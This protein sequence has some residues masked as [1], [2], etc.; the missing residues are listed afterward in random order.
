[1]DGSCRCRSRAT[2][3]IL[4]PAKLRADI[5]VARARSDRLDASKNGSRLAGPCPHQVRAPRTSLGCTLLDPWQFRRKVNHLQGRGG[6]L[7]NH[8]VDLYPP[9]MWFDGRRRWKISSLSP[10]TPTQSWRSMLEVCSFTFR[11]SDRVA[12][13]IISKGSE[14]TQIVCERPLAVA[15]RRWM[16]WTPIS[17]ECGRRSVSSRDRT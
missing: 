13:C 7:Q 15:R 10:D 8:I 17:G 1:L 16:W 5:R 4:P 11:M 3:L 2:F 6:V 14:G 9:I 12:L